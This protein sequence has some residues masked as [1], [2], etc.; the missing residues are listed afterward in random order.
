VETDKGSHRLIQLRDPTTA[1]QPHDQN[2][3]SHH[4]HNTNFTINTHI[5]AINTTAYSILRV[6][7]TDEG[8]HRLIQL[9]NPHG[10]GEW[11]GAFSDESDEFQNNAKLRTELQVRLVVCCFVVVLFVVVFCYK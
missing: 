8:S 2:D 7:E 1:K 11:T 10:K 5:I 3:E 4:H 6:V 9:R